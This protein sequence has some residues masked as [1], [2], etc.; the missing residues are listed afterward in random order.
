MAG[1]VCVYVGGGGGVLFSPVSPSG[2]EL[3]GVILYLE[4][5]HLLKPFL[6]R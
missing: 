5:S 2:Y 3:E 4:A 1:F 6:R